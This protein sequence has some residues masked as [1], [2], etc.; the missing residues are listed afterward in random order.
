MAIAFHCLTSFSVNFNLNIWPSQT[1]GLDFATSPYTNVQFRDAISAIGSSIYRQ[2]RREINR[3]QVFA[4]R[5]FWL[6]KA[7]MSSKSCFFQHLWAAA[8][9]LS[10]S[11]KIILRYLVN[12]KFSLCFTPHSPFGKSVHKHRRLSLGIDEGYRLTFD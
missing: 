10:Y 2:V 9:R 12:P 5:M 1:C 3:T 4:D 7:N 11:A 6:T 8:P